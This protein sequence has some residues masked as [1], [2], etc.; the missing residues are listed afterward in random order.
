M[1]VGTG[2]I[3]PILHK[4]R[5]PH[6]HE[7]SAISTGVLQITLPGKTRGIASHQACLRPAD[8]T[9]RHARLNL[10][11]RPSYIPDPN[12]PH[13]SLIE[14]FIRPVR[15]PDIT[16]RPGDARRHAGGRARTHL[17]SIHI[18]THCTP[19]LQHAS[20]MSPAIQRDRGTGSDGVLGAVGTHHPEP[21]SSRSSRIT[22]RHSQ[23]LGGAV[24][25]AGIGGEIKDPGVI[26]KAAGIYPALER[27][28]SAN[29]RGGRH[30]I[31]ALRQTQRSAT[32]IK[33]RSPGDCL[34]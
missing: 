33:L 2:E 11:G 30:L 16:P 7:I 25:H 34:P 13:R 20:D 8:R 4:L 28:I 12:V 15:F 26:C 1:G 21:G 22:D 24:T 3:N 9:Q 17:H 6:L 31:P 27:Q 5:L 29:H 14:G 32:Q 18:K 23:I 19:A 10:R